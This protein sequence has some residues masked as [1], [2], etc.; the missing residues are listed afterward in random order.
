MQKTAGRKKNLGNFPSIGVIVSISLALFVTGLFGVLIM[1]SSQFEKLVRANIKLQVYLRNGLSETQQQQIQKRLEALPYTLKD[2]TPIQ[3]ISRDDAAKKFIA[4]TGEDFRQ[5]LGENPL[6]DAFLVSI[7]PAYHQE[8]KIKTIQSEL[9]KMN[10]IFQVYYNAGILEDVNRNVTNI[11]LA[12]AGLMIVL[13]I[14]VILL[15][16]NTIRLALFS[17]RFLIRSM[18]LVGARYWFIQRP[19]LARALMYGAIGSIIA[20]VGIYGLIRYANQKIADLAQL[21][22]QEQFILLSGVL[23]LIGMMVSAASTFYS[24]RKYLRMSL[25]ELY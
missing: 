8:E 3:F 7:D 15:I 19:F 10:G 12:L 2:G 5:F 14:T 22:N 11:A 18:Q 21:F 16:N 23:L 25:D 9:E 24:M 17:Q 6:H 13:L 20:T 1:Y 4:E